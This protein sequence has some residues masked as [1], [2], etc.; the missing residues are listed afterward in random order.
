[1]L[2]VD[3]RAQAA[4]RFSATTHESTPADTGTLTFAAHG[5]WTPDPPTMAPFI[6]Y[7]R[8]AETNNTASHGSSE[9]TNAL[10]CVIVRPL[11]LERGHTRKAQ[12]IRTSAAC[13]CY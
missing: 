3:Q 8:L 7:A 4:R 1:V 10:E 13:H 9:R 5:C 11:Q 2:Y 12:V 6:V